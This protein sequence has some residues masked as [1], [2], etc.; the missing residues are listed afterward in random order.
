MI[1]KRTPWKIY[2]AALA[3]IFIGGVL[4]ERARAYFFTIDSTVSVSFVANDR[5]TV[6]LNSATNIPINLQP[7]V[8]YTNGTGSNQVQVLYQSSRTLSGTT[9]TLNINSGALSD[10][11]GTALVL[12]AVK[13]VFIQNTSA[14]NN[15]VIGNAGSNPWAGLLNTTGTITLLPGDFIVVATASSAGWA[16][17]GTSCNILV[18]GTS[19]QTYAIA[20]LGVGT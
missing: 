4:V 6:G 14:T 13:A 9:D 5:R 7:S 11:Y 8:A 2:V 12:T 19:G 3:A 15:I 20:L 16:V 17:S 10:S 1:R 18:T